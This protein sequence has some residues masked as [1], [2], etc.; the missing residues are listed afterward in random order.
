MTRVLDRPRIS[1]INTRCFDRRLVTRGQLVKHAP[2]RGV[3]MFLLFRSPALQQSAGRGR[4]PEGGRDPGGRPR[5][6]PCP[7][8][9]LG[10]PQR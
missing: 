9:R 2:P 1:N 8:P 4:G 7:Q 10:G 5:C 6:G 3:N